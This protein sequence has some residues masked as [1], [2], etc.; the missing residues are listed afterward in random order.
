MTTDKA[1]STSTFFGVVTPDERLGSAE[2]IRSGFIPEFWTAVAHHVFGGGSR[3]SERIAILALIIKIEIPVELIIDSYGFI[4]SLGNWV[5][6]LGCVI[7]NPWGVYW[8][9]IIEVT[10]DPIL[11]IFFAHV[12]CGVNPVVHE[13][14]AHT[15]LDL[16]IEESVFFTEFS[17][18]ICVDNTSINTIKDTFICGPSVPMNLGLDI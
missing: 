2:L 4:N 7:R 1:G 17:A 12:F 5:T 13:H 9:G 11:V 14:D 10:P 8:E 16:F 15:G 3:S 18:A 6:F